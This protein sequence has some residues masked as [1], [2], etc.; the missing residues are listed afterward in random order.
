[1]HLRLLV[2][3]FPAVYRF[4]AAM[5]PKLSGAQLTAGGADGPYASWDVDGQGLLSVLDA[6]AMT[7]VTGARPAPGDTVMLVCR[8]ADVDHGTERGV[9]ASAARPR[10]ERCQDGS[11]KVTA[12]IGHRLADLDNGAVQQRGEYRHGGSLGHGRGA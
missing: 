6:T 11:S 4:Y 2:I 7:A 8:V 9:S 1:M 12:A 5:L 10:R 3:D